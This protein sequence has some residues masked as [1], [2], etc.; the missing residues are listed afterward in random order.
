[1]EIRAHTHKVADVM[2]GTAHGR[3]ARVSC[4]HR[5][6]RTGAILHLFLPLKERK[7]RF[8]AGDTRSGDLTVTP[9]IIGEP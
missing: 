7:R 2:D 1:M 9:E 4:L 3:Y 5:S 6:L 8:W